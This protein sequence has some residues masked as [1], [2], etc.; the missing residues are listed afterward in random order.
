MRRLRFLGRS[1]GYVRAVEVN[2]ALETVIVIA[3]EPVPGR[4]K[5]RL[6]PP[7]THADAAV[8]AAAAITDTLRAAANVP[9]AKRLL[10]WDGRPGT[11]LPAGWTLTPQPSGGLDARLISAFAAAGRGP[12]VLVGMDTPQF[13]PHQLTTFDSRRYDACLGF[14]R[15]GGYWAIGFRDPDWAARTIDGVPMSRSDTGVIQLDRLRAAGLRVQLLDELSDV[16][17]YGDAVTVAA[18]A[19]QT[20]FAHALAAIDS[21]R[22]STATVAG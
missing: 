10:A 16:D 12:A 2:P 15:D 21:R 18:T 17:T 22:L 9:S 4:V 7:L 19:P 5:T 13:E 6:V 3:K 20:E 8:L 11:W 14:A 1:A